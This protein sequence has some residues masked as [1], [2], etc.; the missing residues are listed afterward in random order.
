M[1][2]NIYKKPLLFDIDY[3][4]CNIDI[5][6]LQ[7]LIPAFDT[8]TSGLWRP[9]IIKRSNSNT[10]KVDPLIKADNLVPKTIFDPLN[11]IPEST[12]NYDE[13]EKDPTIN[14]SYCS[15]LE[16]SNYSSKPWSLKDTEGN[17]RNI[18]TET[19]PSLATMISDCCTGACDTRM[20]T[21]DYLPKIPVINQNYLTSFY[22]FKYLKQ[23]PA[24]NNPGLGFEDFIKLDPNKM[25]SFELC[26]SLVIDWKIRE[27]ISEIIYD[28]MTSQHINIEQHNKSFNKSFNTNKTCGNFILT[29]INPATTGVHPDYPI[30]SGLIGDTDQ[31]RVTLS[32]S[33]LLPSTED[34]TPP[35]GFSRNTYDNIF[36]HDERIGSHWKWNYNSGV[37]CWYRYFNTGIPES[38]D[39]RPIKGVDL[40]ISPG[41]VFYATNDGPEPLTVAYEE[42][43]EIK[44]CPSGMKLL[45]N[46]SV[47]GVVPSGSFFTYISSNIYPQFLDLYNRIDEA[48]ILDNT[49]MTPKQKFDLA[50]LLSTAPQYDQITI[51]LLKRNNSYTYEINEYK[52]ISGFNK[53]MSTS[54]IGSVSKLNYIQNK[55][56]LINT[57]ADKYGAYLWCPPKETTTLKLKNSI[58][59]Q[60]LVNL[61]FDMVLDKKDTLFRTANCATTTEC[62]D[63]TISKSFTYNQ[64]FVLGN[65]DFATKTD[66]STRYDTKCSDDSLSIYKTAKT[67]G[68][69]LNNNLISEKIYNSGCS[70]LEDNYPRI[71]TSGTSNSCNS[72]GPD[73]TYKLSIVN[74]E[75]ICKDYTGSWSWCD[76]KLATLYNNADNP[77]G[78]RLSRSILD[79]TLYFKRSYP[80]TVFNPHIDRIAFHNQGGVYYVSNLFGGLRGTTVFT[81]SAISQ[82]PDNLLSIVFETKD[83]GIK[84]YNVSVEKLRGPEEDSYS[85]KAFPIKDKC[86]CYSLT[87]I[88]DY[89]YKC[90]NDGPITYSNNAVL[91]TPSV[92]TANSPRIKS[93]GGYDIIKVAE[94]L[95]GSDIIKNIS[96]T[97]QKIADIKI[98]ILEST[99]IEEIENLQRILEELEATLIDLQSSLSS[100]TIPNHPTINSI[101]PFVDSQIDPLNPY[102][103]EKSVTISL[104]NYATTNWSLKLPSYDTIHSD[105]W[106]EV[107]ENVNLFK[108]NIFDTDPETGDFISSP[109]LGYQR[110]TTKVNLNNITLYDQQKKVF[111]PK[112]GGISSSVNI[113][114]TNPYLAGLL[115]DEFYLYPPTGTLCESN[116]IFG[117]RGDEITSV[118]I[119]FSR[120][121]R[122]QILNFSIPAYSSLGTLKKGFFHPNSGLTFD[123][124]YT[125]FTPIIKDDKNNTYYIDYE[126]EKFKKDD[127]Y[128]EGLVLIGEMNS[129]IENILRNIN[130]FSDHRK[131]R[132]YLKLPDG[133]YLYDNPNSFGFMNKNNLFIGEPFMFE[134]VSSEDKVNLQGPWLPACAKEP[135][136]FNFLYNYQPTGNNI[137]A[138][139]TNKYPLSIVSVSKNINKPKVV[140][141][142]GVRPYFCVAEKESVVV[143]IYDSIENLSEDETILINKNSVVLLTNGERWRYKEGNKNSL[144]SYEWTDYN[145]LYRNF[146]DLHINYTSKNKNSYVYNTLLSCDQ[147]VTII[148]KENPKQK[149]T[150]KII[151]KSIYCYDTDKYGNILSFNDT[152]KERYI[153]IYTRFKLDKQ[154]KYNNVYLDF[155]NLHNNFNNLD[156]VDS[157]VL[158]RN[159]DPLL[160]K[161]LDILLDN[162][163]FAT[164]WADL[165]DF[166]N[167]LS[168]ELSNYIYPNSYINDNYPSSIYNQLFNK[169]II[170]NTDYQ[171][172]NYII[173]P[174]NL[175]SIDVS[176][177][178]LVYYAIHQKYNIDNNDYLTKKNFNLQDNYLPLLDLNFI[179]TPG[180]TNQ[181]L[182]M[183]LSENIQST[184]ENGELL[185]GKILVSG[186]YKNLSANHNWGDFK[187]PNDAKYF[188]INI[189]PKHKLKSAISFND[190]TTFFSNTLRVDDPPFQ[191]FSLNTTE[192]YN[193]TCSAGISKPSIP[194]YNNIN[195]INNTINFN[196]FNT[197]IFNTDVFARYAIYCDTDKVGECSSIS[198]GINTAG[199]TTVKADYNIY[200]NKHKTIKDITTNNIPFMLSYDAGVYNIIGNTGI[201]YIQRFELEPNNTLYPESSCDPTVGPRPAQEKY[202]VLNPEYQSLLSQSMVNDHTN[203][204]KNTDILAN[205]MFFRLLYGEKQK[206]NLER[207]DGSNDQISLLD[208]LRY[209]YPKIEAKD[210]YKNIPYDL[211]IN[212]NSSNRK[213]DGSI[214][215]NG[216]LTENSTVSIKINDLIINIKIIKND[217]KIKAIAS[218]SGYDDIESNIYSETIKQY[219]LIVSTS[220]QIYASNANEK[221]IG[222]IH[223]CKERRQLTFGMAAK[224]IKAEIVVPSC[225][226]VTENDIASFP[227]WKTEDNPGGKVCSRG[228][229][230]DFTTCPE[231]HPVYFEYN[232]GCANTNAV[233][234]LGCT[235]RGVGKIILNGECG[236]AGPSTISTLS[237][238][239]IARGVFNGC[240]VAGGYTNPVSDGAFAGGGNI[241]SQVSSVVIASPAAISLNPRQDSS[242]CGVCFTLD[243]DE[244][245]EGRKRY[246]KLGRGWPPTPVN[247]SDACECTPYEYGYCRNSEKIAECVCPTLNYEY[248]EF[249]YNFQY[250]RHSITLKGFKRKLTGYLENPGITSD[251]PPGG[252]PPPP[253]SYVLGDLS[254]KLTFT[255]ECMPIVCVSSEPATYYIF[256]KETTIHN[257]KYNP[258]CATNLCNITYNNNN[259]TI[260][261]IGGTTKCIKYKIRNDCPKL[262]IT[263]PND[264]FTVSDSINSSCDSCGVE[265][266]EIEMIEQHSNWDIITETRT[267]VLGYILSGGNP[268]INGPVPLGGTQTVSCRTCPGSCPD[269]ACNGL[270]ST[271]A[272]GG[273]CGMSAPDS[274]PWSTCISL[275]GGRVYGN[276]VYG[277]DI[278]IGFDVITSTS[279]G[280]RYIEE[281][282][283]N[284]DQAYQN[285]AACKNNKDKYSLNDIVE[286]V[287][288]GSCSSLQIGS[289]SY[290][291]ISY[292][293]T[294]GAPAFTQG[295]VSVSVAYYTYQYRRPKTVQD[296]LRGV[297]TSIKCNEQ[298]SICSGGL[299]ISSTYKTNDCNTQPT[300]YNTSTEPCNEDNYCCKVGKIEYE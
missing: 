86:K 126:K 269:N 20:K 247:T 59:N 17:T 201:K 33:R 280:G 87:S 239:G 174:D 130:N 145:Y 291:S 164:K 283:N 135:V 93:Y 261:L 165:I 148:N 279:A 273:L 222:P 184:L 240:Y 217:G 141:I 84:I 89:P 160:Q 265:T 223:Q 151:E 241:E 233:P 9:V 211:D 295:S 2:C 215:I 55:T 124:S 251:S 154:L 156:G 137:L 47:T 300:C 249:P 143:S 65:V 271:A 297:E 203:L 234:Y 179:P 166:D 66:T 227:R 118:S 136:E 53:D 256:N 181:S 91:F 22:D 153:K 286:G 107:L 270:T 39:N 204:V 288:P 264:S 202:S 102:S 138:Y 170:N 219:N 214:S 43:M 120:V 52:Q 76:E 254:G 216:K 49:N 64:K 72:C 125:N 263:V 5:A 155:S 10:N 220:D 74:A 276:T 38:E 238:N 199:W 54:K 176:Y 67:A 162:T 228:E 252:P 161:E 142:P 177:T 159:F 275:A 274:F 193:Q 35:Y 253:P 158:Y 289:V 103:C 48:D 208:L 57:L 134:Y 104:N 18:Q 28:E 96:I 259:L 101:L 206:I 178:G 231:D 213:I 258:N 113:E 224:I 70:V 192:N 294:L 98:Q 106:A 147:D 80:A 144:S 235:N 250:C 7:S 114:L 200:Q 77:T 109:N 128:A 257:L 190:N 82:T 205:E 243:S 30:F 246:N 12:K 44:P 27:N 42:K 285:V 221:Y 248:T 299:R 172:F 157:L 116:S 207:I 287:V 152:S 71:I 121:P 225:K 79:G 245:V 232:L 194:N 37:L 175:S 267:C 58:K 187:S 132:L 163:L 244:W 230:Y 14:C 127:N 3:N 23:F 237:S 19:S 296:I 266:D 100:F 150:S 32:S 11:C 94:F 191:L 78:D 298:A 83:V 31:T 236:S 196:T 40:Y 186:I 212:S 284:M 281:W 255:E 123:Q 292:R 293:A 209:S 69:Y 195:I 110:F 60:C 6:K 198:C 50:A 262:E 229:P 242:S 63:N 95:G 119:K 46:G 278:P 1:G 36:I 183:S 122:K 16:P 260:S 115:G 171:N 188:W 56:D 185:K 169:I 112:D 68:I 277:C 85:C 81:N 182:R 73:S 62:S 24:T 75:T 61:E 92:S 41:D 21:D 146:S 29:Q 167:K 180:E 51:D 99:D 282:V 13:L 129:D 105:I 34:F 218:I 226:D 111:I 272:G 168:N 197:Q 25:R 45:K 290:P 149:Y 26:P 4:E 210:V 88:T 189:N 133:W 173:T 8:E 139:N 131:L 117:G 90:G 97:K 108:A 140:D 268:N 15:A